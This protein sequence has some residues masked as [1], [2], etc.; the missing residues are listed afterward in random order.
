MQKRDP[1]MTDFDKRNQW[2]FGM[3]TPSSIDVES[4]LIYTAKYTAAKVVDI[5]TMESRLHWK[6]ALLRVIGAI[7]RR[8]GRLI[9]S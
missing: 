7:T 8:I 5:K 6:E 1:E 3:K 4:T 9:A 2:H